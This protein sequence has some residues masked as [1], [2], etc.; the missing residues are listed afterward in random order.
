MFGHVHMIA[1]A[2]AEG[3]RHV[4]GTEVPL[5]R[6][7]ETLPAIV[8]EKTGALV[9]QKKFAHIPLCTPQQLADDDAVI[10][11]TPTRFGNM[12]GQMRQFF[13]ATGGIWKAGALVG[14]VG[15]VFTSSGT[16]HCWQESTL[17]SVHTTLLHHG[18]LIAG[19]L[20]S[21]EGPNRIDEVRRGAPLTVHQ[22]LPAMTG[23]GGQA[24]TNWPVH[25]SREDMWQELHQSWCKN[26]FKTTFLLS[27]SMINDKNLILPTGSLQNYFHKKWQDSLSSQALLSYKE[28]SRCRL[29]LGVMKSIK[30]RLPCMPDTKANWRSDQRYP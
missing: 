17:M 19:L 4:P 11:G 9:A 14:K 3:A 8:M 22:Q 28:G 7:P 5:A 15:S 16:Q 18:M 10:F 30:K 6:V 26:N 29:L 1:E 13:D 23:S 25:G 2:V 24:K 27:Y 20:Y 21:F 12:C